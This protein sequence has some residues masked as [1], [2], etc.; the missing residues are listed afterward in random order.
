M[1]RPATASDAAR[2]AEIYRPYVTDTATS[3]EET[4][5]DAAE[6]ER[7]MAAAHVWLVDESDGEVRGYAYA[8]PWRSRHA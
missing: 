4:P 5:P 6:I 8:T 2:I 1:I 7:R 3:F